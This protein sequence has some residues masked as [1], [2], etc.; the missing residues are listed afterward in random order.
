[1][2]QSWKALAES[3]YPAPARGK[4]AICVSQGPS[5]EG[6][7]PV[8]AGSVRHRRKLANPTALSSDCRLQSSRVV[9]SSRRPF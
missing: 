8:L 2:H 3:P 4:S 9:S 1:V 6:L 7:D 5:E